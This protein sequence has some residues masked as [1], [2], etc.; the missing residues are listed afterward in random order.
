MICLGQAADI[1]DAMGIDRNVVVHMGEYSDINDDDYCC[2]YCSRNSG[3]TR[4]ELIDVNA[5]IM[6]DIVKK[7]L[8]RMVRSR[9]SGVL[10]AT[11]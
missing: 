5:K 11:G 6:C 1:N 9:I 10:S 8:W 4:L 3:Q 2:D 7:I